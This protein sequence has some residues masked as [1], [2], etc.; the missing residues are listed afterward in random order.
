MT[1]ET[2]RHLDEAAFRELVRTKWTISLILTA[3]IL[4]IYFGFILI[5]AFAKD[6]FMIKIGTHMTLGLPVGLGVILSACILTGI[7][8]FWAN[9]SYDA[10]VRRIIR[11][12][13]GK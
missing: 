8:V 7:Y 11:S 3:L 2:G 9:T 5:L 1:A 13:R 6:V 12:M 4:G 10:A